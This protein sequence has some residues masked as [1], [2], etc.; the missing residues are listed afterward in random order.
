MKPTSAYR[1]E[2]APVGGFAT[3]GRTMASGEA[4]PRADV[5]LIAVVLPRSPF[6]TTLGW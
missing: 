3:F 5:S 1:I 4:A 6:Q 2:P